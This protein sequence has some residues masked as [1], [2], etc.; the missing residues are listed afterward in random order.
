MADDAVALDSNEKRRDPSILIVVFELNQMPH[1]SKELSVSAGYIQVSSDMAYI[2]N[3][4]LFYVID[5]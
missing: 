1:L 4:S 5:D 2:L 3:C